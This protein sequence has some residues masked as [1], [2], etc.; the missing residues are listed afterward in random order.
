[1]MMEQSL[2]PTAN[3]IAGKKK[4]AGGRA[5]RSFLNERGGMYRLEGGRWGEEKFM[6]MD[7]FSRS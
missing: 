4:P 2:E 1:M 5:N 7:G 3:Q 6:W